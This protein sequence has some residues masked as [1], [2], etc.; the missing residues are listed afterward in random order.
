MGVGMQEL[1][2]ERGR[3]TASFEA[4]ALPSLHRASSWG[5]LANS[6]S[7]AMEQEQLLPAHC[8][9]CQ[10]PQCGQCMQEAPGCSALNSGTLRQ[11]RHVTS[12]VPGVRPSSRSTPL[13]RRRRQVVEGAALLPTHERFSLCRRHVLG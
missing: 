3:L 7:W 12:G 2:V 10:H 4:E 8:G 13:S 6:R 5:S 11:V 1:E 9:W